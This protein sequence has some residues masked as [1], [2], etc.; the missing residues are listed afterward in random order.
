MC[1][2]IESSHRVMLIVE[3]DPLLRRLLAMSTPK[4]LQIELDIHASGATLDL[5]AD[6]CPWQGALIDW[7]LPDENG[8]EIAHRLRAR[9]PNLPIAIWSAAAYLAG[10]EARQA[11]YMFVAKPDS[12]TEVLKAFGWVGPDE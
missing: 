1:E 12:I 10:E 7:M 4:D 5:S 11:G 8:L 6:E 9:Y 3:D 2:P